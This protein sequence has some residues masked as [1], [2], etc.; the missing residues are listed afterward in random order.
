[1]GDEHRWTGTVGR[2]KEDHMELTIM[3]V[4][5][6]GVLGWGVRVM[7]W[8]TVKAPVGLTQGIVWR[9]GRIWR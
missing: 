1:M 5:A 9:R 7:P 8:R 4:L 2:N 3:V 6:I